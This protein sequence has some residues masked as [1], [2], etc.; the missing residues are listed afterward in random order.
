[1]LRLLLG[2][3]AAAADTPPKW[4]DVQY[5]A[6]SV[7]TAPLSAAVGN[8]LL[9]RKLRDF[10]AGRSAPRAAAFVAAR[11]SLG[12]ELG[13]AYSNA[14]GGAFGPFVDELG[15]NAGVYPRTLEH[16]HAF[17]LHYSAAL[18]LANHNGIAGRFGGDGREDVVLRRFLPS[19]TVV[20]NRALEP[21][22]FQRP[23]S[24]QLRNKTVLVVHPF[25]ETIRSQYA[26]RLNG[27]RFFDNGDVLPIL[28]EL[29]VV[30]AF[31]TLADAPKPHASWSESLDEMKRLIDAAAPFDV[32]LLGCGSY[33]L[34]LLGHVRN[35]H[36]VPA[37]YMG[38]GLQLLF[39]IKGRRWTDRPE[40]RF[41]E[42]W[43]HPSREETPPGADKVEGGSYW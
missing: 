26:K 10:F 1:M 11:L 18:S 33:G 32:A 8:E 13:I 30:R 3:A 39:G 21:F 43:V 41:N 28:R 25:T 9:G 42:H 2:L 29:K 27:A 36:G 22:Y 31:T 20:G 17:W 38:G 7:W 5:E 6:G 35:T 40:W 19:S 16:A 23:W 24:A 4:N 37:I 12:A 14:T 34:P 15:N